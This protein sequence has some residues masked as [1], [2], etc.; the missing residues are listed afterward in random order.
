MITEDFDVT[1][2]LKFI[3][4]DAPPSE[5]LSGIVSMAITITEA[6]ARRADIVKYAAFE[7]AAAY[8]MMTIAAETKKEIA[9]NALKNI[10][11]LVKSYEP[12]TKH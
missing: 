2:F 12:E 9:L 8:M 10:N 7:G 11:N 6:F 3:D 1:E 4:G 5:K